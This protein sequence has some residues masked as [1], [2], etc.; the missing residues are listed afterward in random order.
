[1]ITPTRTIQRTPTGIPGLDELIEGG[2]LKS[3]THLIAGET[4]TGKTI[5]SLQFL[6]HGVKIGE[7]G[8]YMA[9]DEDRE[10]VIRGAEGFGWDVS[11]LLEKNL[12][13]ITQ[14]VPGFAEKFKK[15]YI[16]AAV[17]SVI[18]G[19]RQ[20][21]MRIGATRLVIDPI[22][23]LLTKEEDLPFTREYIRELVLAIER[24]LGCTTLIVSEV[25]TG[26]NTLSRFGVE[27]FL[28]S[29]I[30]T[31]GILRKGNE[32]YRTLCVRKM[33]WTA[34]DPV[35][36]KFRIVRGEGIVVEGPISE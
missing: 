31:L 30:I 23:P 8:I 19:I 26:S 34:V 11:S 35:L 17:G 15:K 6:L 21:M 9:I 18:V 12:L 5:F 36:Y 2:L 33:R 29:G 22:A 7:R 24:E 16:E 4:G 1:L 13:S 20:E 3:R 27:E 32:V 14:I 25:P 10:N 28:A